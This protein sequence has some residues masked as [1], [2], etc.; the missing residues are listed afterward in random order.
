MVDVT[1]I[2]TPG[3]PVVIRCKRDKSVAEFDTSVVELIGGCLLCEPILANGKAVNF[4]VPGIQLEMQIFDKNTAKIYAWHELDI[5]LGYYKKKTLCQLIYVKDTPVEIN[6][7]SGYRQYVAIPGKMVY[8]RNP[9]TDVLI[10]DVSNAGLGFIMEQ[11]GEFE[12]G[13]VV[14]V[15]FS[16]EEGRYRFDLKCQV[17]RERQMENGKFEY[18]C[19]V[20]TPPQ[21]LGA[22]VA[23]KQVEERKRVLGHI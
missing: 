21:S 23:H 1:E 7:R 17:V 3:V 19:M 14:R 8:F 20:L 11:K 5:K 16:D 6:R 9:P 13:K 12:P 22:Y 18:G 4:Q 10:R 15:G 2:M